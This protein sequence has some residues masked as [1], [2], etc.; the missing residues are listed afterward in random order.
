MIK[1]QRQG[2]ALV[3]TIQLANS[4]RGKVVLTSSA[5]GASRGVMAVFPVAGGQSVTTATLDDCMNELTPA[6]VTAILCAQERA[7]GSGR[8][9]PLEAP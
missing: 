1:W 2:P 8:L 4:R 7:F 3:G 5:S 6:Q 9:P